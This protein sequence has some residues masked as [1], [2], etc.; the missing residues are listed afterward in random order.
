MLGIIY[1]LNISSPRKYPLKTIITIREGAGLL[2]VASTLE[3]I[4]VIRS[5][6]WFRSTAIALGGER[7]LQAGD[8]Y[9]SHK[10]NVLRLAWRIVKGK[11]NIETARITIPEGFTIDEIASLFDTRFPKFNQEDFL[12][13]AKE[14]YMFPD[15]YFMEVSATASSTIHIL[16]D[17]FDKKIESY[18]NEIA[19]SSHT[20]DDV[21]NMASILEEEAVTSEDRKI[22]S[23]ILWKRIKL[24][25][26]LQVD[27]TLKY[28]TGRGSDQLTTDDLKMDSPYNSYTNR[29]LPPTPISN[30][31]VDA[32]EAAL[33]PRETP[34]LYFLTDKNG[35]MHYS[36][37]FEEHKK[38]KQK[39][40]P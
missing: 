7:G 36:K 5:P 22:I 2:E 30:P 37:T 20:F 12:S 34:F 18:K 33:H 25:M 4:N 28:I 24:G 6:F 31:G 21:I 14:G 38:N 13:M 35:E 8:Y 16:E 40:L 29:G 23:G 15:T 1:W 3:K 17:N 27:A 9:L 39:Y 11:K 26:P 19:S 10:E 32:I